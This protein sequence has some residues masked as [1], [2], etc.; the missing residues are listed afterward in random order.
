MTKRRFDLRNVVKIGVTCLAVCMMFSGCDKNPN[1]NGD[2][3]IEPP[4]PDRVVINGVTWA[5]RN[6]DE[7]GTFAEKPESFG[8]LYQW[9]KKTAWATSGSV[10]GWS[11]TALTTHTQWQAINDPSPDGWRIATKAD[12]DKLLEK[13]KVSCERTTRNGVYG[14]KFTDLTT[15]AT[16]FFPG[17]V[18]RN[19]DKGSLSSGGSGGLVSSGWYWSSTRLNEGQAYYVYLPAGGSDGSIKEGFYFD[20]GLTV[21]CVLK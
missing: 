10:S 15:K 19:Y 13:S 17:V 7:P 18:Y 14:H 21:R 9:N 16:L 20:Y 5:S 2:D 3:P 8:K 6:V 11:G 1:G 4:G 12:F